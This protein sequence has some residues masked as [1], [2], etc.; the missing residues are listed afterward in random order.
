MYIKQEIPNGWIAAKTHRRDIPFTSI[1]YK[2]IT[3]WLWRNRHAEPIETV[4]IPE[5]HIRQDNLIANYY[6]RIRS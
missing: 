1:P 5:S 4:I 6:K 2:V 3:D